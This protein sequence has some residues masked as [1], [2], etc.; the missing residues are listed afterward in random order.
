MDLGEWDKAYEDAYGPGYAEVEEW[1]AV[2][3]F[4]GRYEVSS[5]GRVRSLDQFV[6]LVTRRGVE[7]RRFSPGKL[8]KPGP[9]RSGHVSVAVGKG[10]SVGVHRLVCEAFHGPCPEN[11]ECLHRNHNPADNRAANLKWGTR[12]QNL[13]MDYAAGSRPKPTWLAGSRWRK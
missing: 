10:H 1:R 13:K 6:R 9:S 12:S 5:L 3:G 11:N 2:V 8:L 4:E 7:T